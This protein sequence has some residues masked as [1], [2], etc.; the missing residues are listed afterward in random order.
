MI[1]ITLYDRTT[2]RLADYTIR[3]SRTEDADLQVSLDANLGWVAG[4]HDAA[5]TYVDPDGAVQPRTPEALA[6][7]LY[8]P[9][10]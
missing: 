6:A 1:D 2:R 10:T 5:A 3:V 8:T 7:R 9:E 4:A